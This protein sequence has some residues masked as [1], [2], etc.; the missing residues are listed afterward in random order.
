L[1][2][3]GFGLIGWVDDYRKVIQRNSKG[4]SAASKFFWQSVIALLVALYLAMTAELPQHTDMIVPFFKE[5]AIP[6]G[7]SL[8]ILLTYLVIV[9]TSN[10]V[11]LTDGL[12]GLA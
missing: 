12:D 10:A 3:L 4:L 1:T 7:A 9:G 11:N 5:V 6:L 2:T 8:F